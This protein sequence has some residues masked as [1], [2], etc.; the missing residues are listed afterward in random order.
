MGLCAYSIFLVR[1]LGRG[2]LLADLE[3]LGL[4]SGEKM[5]GVPL[6]AQE[7]RN[8]LR[9]S[10]PLSVVELA[11]ADSQFAALLSERPDAFI[12]WLW[13]AVSEASVAY[14]FIPGGGDFPYYEQGRRTDAVTVEQL[15]ELVETGA[16]RV[17]HPLMLFA[18]RTGVCDWASETKSMLVE[19]RA[20]LGCLLILGERDPES[21]SL[22]LF[23]PA[24]LYERVRDEL[25]HLQARTPAG[26]TR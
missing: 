21:G 16:V 10:C 24:T 26:P 23:E 7:S 6:D 8:E 15:G 18:A 19:T 13:L 9:A 5:L 4:V 1:E 14:A 12:E 22:D 25:Q 3:R 17:L 20:A 2:P 11:L